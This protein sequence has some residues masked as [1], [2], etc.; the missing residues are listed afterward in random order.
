MEKEVA[1]RIALIMRYKKQYKLF[2]EGNLNGKAI[3]KVIYEF[4]AREGYKLGPE[5]KE[6]VHLCLGT[7]LCVITGG[8]GTGKTSVLKCVYHIIREAGGEINQMALAG[9]AAR[10]MSEATGLPA[11]TIAGF[12][13]DDVT[14]YHADNTFVIDEASM[15]DLPMTF[16]ILRR[17][18]DGCRLILVGDAEQLPPIGPGLV[19][20]LLAKSMVGIVPTVELKRVYRQEGT[21]GIPAVAAAIR[22]GKNSMPTIPDL[23]EYSGLGKGVSIYNAKASEMAE[24]IMRVYED[25]GASDP[26]ADVRVLAITREDKPHGVDGI[27]KA[28]HV[29]YSQDKKRVLGYSEEQAPW[30]APGQFAEG[31]PVMW[32][33]NEW[34]R[35]LFN[36]TLG[37]VE[38]AYDAPVVEKHDPG[39]HFSANINFDTGKKDVTIS[40]LD[41]MVLAYAITVHK[42]Q[43][44]QFKRVIIPIAKVP[45]LD[46]ALVYTAV[47]RAVEQVV[48]VG[49]IDVA[50]AAVE[51]GA[52]AD[53]RS[54]GLGH[55]LRLTIGEGV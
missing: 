24:A 41:S 4:E 53:K 29:K 28:F 5:Q 21:S 47:T 22:G 46:K 38:K 54:V 8:A 2:G 31:E 3:N 48:L 23:P 12:L 35:E 20:H 30:K 25:L 45:L 33:Q 49:D 40:D 51:G 18:P 43:G 17:L 37:V 34:E 55:M 42:S 39:E 10:R 36:G 15:L 26:E 13:T 6:A 11:R 14:V 32:T 52:N 50:R 16:R 44:S 7:N 19:F 27:N 1:E 9:R